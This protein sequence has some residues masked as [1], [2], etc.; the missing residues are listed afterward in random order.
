MVQ[1]SLKQSSLEHT[2]PFKTQEGNYGD[3][4]LLFKLKIQMF[5]YIYTDILTFITLTYLILLQNAY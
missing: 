2:P 5:T 1:P 3:N 4:F